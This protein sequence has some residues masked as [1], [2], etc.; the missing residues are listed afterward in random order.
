V[1]GSNA[2]DQP[3]TQGFLSWPNKYFRRPALLVQLRSVTGPAGH[4]RAWNRRSG[5]FSV[6]N[7]DL[8]EALRMGILL[9]PAGG[10]PWRIGGAAGAQ[11]WVA[12][13]P[14]PFGAAAVGYA[15]QPGCA[16]QHGAAV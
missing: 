16:A 12:G 5:A 13:A 1:T 9:R 7:D 4:L 6:C 2:T 14:R 15:R 3:R 8:R 11:R 10:P